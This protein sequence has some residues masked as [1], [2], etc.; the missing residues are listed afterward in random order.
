MFNSESIR[1][2]LGA[3]LQEA[4]KALE[5]G[6]YP[7]GAVFVDSNGKGEII[8]MN[9]CFTL[10]DVTAHA[11]IL[12]I[13]K[14]GSKI[15]KDTPNEYYLFTSLEPCFG[16]SFYLAR[17]NVKHIYSALKDPHKGGTSDLKSQEQF[18]SFFK[19]I[20]LFNE[21]FKDMA[22]QSK[23]LMQKYFLNKGRKDAAAF[24]GYGEEK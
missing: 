23:E 11:E 1:S 7:I 13:R 19:N 10:D 15:H 17:T 12:G 24:Y 2:Y 20:E 3:A 6:N 9:E 22:I 21:P 5:L 16:C 14:L 18:Q 4:K 8:E